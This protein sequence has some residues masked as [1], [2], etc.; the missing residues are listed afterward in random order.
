M[1][2][3]VL[4]QHAAPHLI[5]SAGVVVDQTLL[6]FDHLHGEAASTAVDAPAPLGPI[7][8][9]A[10][11]RLDAFARVRG[12][13][14]NFFAYGE[15]VDI[16]LRL[17][18]EGARCNLAGNARALHRHSVTLSSGSSKKNELLG[19][20]RG[21]MLRRYGVL[22]EPQRA[23]RTVV[24]ESVISIGQLVLDRNGAGIR[25]RINGWRAARSLPIRSVPEGSALELRLHEAL[26]RRY[27]QARDTR[28]LSQLRK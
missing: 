4:V 1:V 17:R 7:G 10:L 27:R 25:G 19:W 20:S 12:F 18:A 8:G 6:P 11:Y 23:A 16:A 3:G 22:R 14:E 5:D 24:A 26:T 15:D 28:A 13:D 21:Y 2:A 9:A